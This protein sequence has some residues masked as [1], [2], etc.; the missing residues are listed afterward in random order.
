MKWS[1]RESP[2]VTNLDS[3]IVTREFGCFLS[4]RI[5]SFRNVSS[6][7]WKEAV[8]LRLNLWHHSVN[9]N[10]AIVFHQSNR[11]DAAHAAACVN[12]QF[13]GQLTRL[14]WEYFSPWSS[15]LL[16]HSQQWDRPR[17]SDLSPEEQTPP[18]LTSSLQNAYARVKLLLLSTSGRHL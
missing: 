14:C 1:K 17:C 18:S 13:T 7:G 12:R 3:T 10:E 16:A 6:T 15:R 8:F 2:F 5:A 9:Q 11:I 4:L